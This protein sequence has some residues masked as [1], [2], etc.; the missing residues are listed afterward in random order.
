M[1][2]VLGD[3]RMSV[4]AGIWNV[5]GAGID[6]AALQAISL[7]SAQYGPDG[8]A[9]YWNDTLG[10]L[11]RP[12]YTTQESRFEQQPI[13]TPSRKILTWDG[14]LDNREQ[15]R[16]M[17]S[18]EIPPQETDVGIVVA[19]VER[20]GTETFE[21]LRGDWAL[22]I[23]DPRAME[24]IL[25]RDYLGIRHLFY[26][27]V[28]GRIIWCTCLAPLALSGDKFT[29][30]DEYIAGYLAFHPDAHLTPYQEI[31]SVPP[32]SFVHIRELGTKV[33][34]Y[35]RFNTDAET[36][37]KTDAEYEE[38]YR[39]LFR[40]AV[41]R[42]L[43]TDSP[44]L[45]ELSGGLDSSSIVCTA[46]DILRKKQ[47]SVPRLDTLSY[48]DSNEP[49]EDDYAHFSQVEEKRGR[50]GFRVDLKG[51]GQS[52]P[53]EYSSFPATPGFGS[54]A[55]IKTAFS[56][57]LAG[58]EYRVMLSGTGGDEINGQPLDPCVLMAEILLRL[59]FVELGKSLTVWS[60]RL[61]K[62]WIELL[63]QT[64]LQFFPA[65]LRAHFVEIGM[66]EPWVDQKFAKK[67]KF[68]DRQLE[69]VDRVGFLRPSARD[70]VQTIETLRRQFTFMSPSPIEKRYPYL[71]QEFVEYLMSVPLSQLLRPGE[72]RSLMR[73][74]LTG[75]L[76][77]DVAARK[78]KTGAAR[79]YSVTLE[80]NWT[81]I[82][83]L[84][85][86]PFVACAGYV[87][88]KNFR[89]ALVEMRNGQVPRYFLRLL[90]A[91]SLELWLREVTSRGV[92][93]IEPDRLAKVRPEI[94][95]DRLRTNRH[96]QQSADQSTLEVMRSGD[97]DS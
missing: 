37:Y 11:Y 70:G 61:R 80:R 24:L 38:H 6:R 41:R 5:N 18:T 52:L 71:D 32:G 82:D 14:R 13:K 23:W 73:R 56:E 33:Q 60:L 1:G 29:L 91:L 88:P 97:R 69:R 54:R 81:Q 57:F 28:P 74:S 59:R 58:R 51:S 4:Q 19:A 7:A 79:C 20:W 12:H 76:P 96:H 86:D 85:R 66:I 92:I 34:S 62:P 27:P 64:V 40:Q 21:R 15:L 44:V 47:A 42:R 26:Y 43:R 49:G 95:A 94:V 39:Y 53:L 16:T 36:R 31:L 46:D 50:I 3:R 22:A 9:F 87:D 84:L 72:R 65:A 45:S 55:E 90:K 75:L 83:H 77:R 67:F 2:T 30:C 93:A 89:A 17:L 63:F 10:M 8:E 78:T 35:W 25:A 68:G 48:Y